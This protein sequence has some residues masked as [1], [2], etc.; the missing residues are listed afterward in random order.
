[1]IEIIFFKKKKIVASCELCDKIYELLQKSYHNR[2]YK[3]SVHK[4]ES[5]ADVLRYKPDLHVDF[6]ICAF[7][8]RIRE[9]VEEVRLFCFLFF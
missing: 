8:S 3:I 4:C 1:M 7:D 6:V 5:I 9:N 2:G